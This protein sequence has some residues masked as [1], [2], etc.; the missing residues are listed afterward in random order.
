ISRWTGSSS[1]SQVTSSTT[2]NSWNRSRDN[3]KRA[4]RFP[5][6]PTSLT[7]PTRPKAAPWASERKPQSELT[8][9]L[10]R[11]TEV[12]GEA[13]RLQQRPVSRAR[14]RDDGARAEAARVDRVEHVEQLAERFDVGAAAEVEHLAHANVHLLLRHAA[15]A[16]HGLARPELLERRP[17]GS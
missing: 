9:A 15:A 1:S 16:V 10:L 7:R 2:W 14:R 11:P 5:F 13:G 8:N 4:G 12:A 3:K 6:L 17:A